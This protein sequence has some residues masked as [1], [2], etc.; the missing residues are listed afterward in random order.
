MRR[1]QNIGRNSS[2]EHPQL[3]QPLQGLLFAAHFSFHILSRGQKKHT[4][5]NNPLGDTFSK[6]QQVIHSLSPHLH[7]G[8]LA[9]LFLLASAVLSQQHGALCFWGRD[10]PI[11]GTK[12]QSFP[13]LALTTT[14]T[15][16]RGPE[17]RVR[18]K[19]HSPFALLRHSLPASSNL[20]PRKRQSWAA[21]FN[22]LP[23]TSASFRAVV[24][25]SIS[26]WEIHWFTETKFQRLAV[27]YLRKIKKRNNLIL[28]ANYH[29]TRTLKVFY[30]FT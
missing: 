5:T 13:W 29:P 11:F 9:T 23:K 14:A 16:T 26:Y 4:A 28:L 12:A 17:N 15:S 20:P 25:T 19:S 3:S 6:V 22:T 1:T 2:P 21:Y 24:W 7:L 18:W 27:S 10:T 8:H 30:S